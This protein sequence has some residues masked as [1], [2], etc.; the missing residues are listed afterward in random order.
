MKFLNEKRFF[1]I[2]N[3][4]SIL[5]SLIFIVTTILFFWNR[6]YK[7]SLTLDTDIFNHY[8]SFFAGIF[9]IPTTILVYLTY[10]TQKKELE[11]ARKTTQIQ[12]FENT[13]FNLLTNHREVTK[14]L[15]E[16]WYKYSNSR[17]EEQSRAFDGKI[18]IDI[19]V[20]LIKTILHGLEIKYY[21]DFVDKQWLN[22]EYLNFDGYLPFDNFRLFELNF[23]FI[24]ENKKNDPLGKVIFEKSKLANPEGLPFIYERIFV[25]NRSSL[26]HYF[27][28]LYHFVKLVDEYKG[29]DNLY[30]KDEI[31]EM[32]R[33]YVRLIRAQL[34][35]NELILLALNSISEYGKA[36]IPLIERY[37]LL[38]NVNIHAELNFMEGLLE[39][40]PHF[41]QPL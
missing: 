33:K 25:L 32:K 41:K 20:N 6:T 21:L 17:R 12:Q 3:W 37:K 24:N 14:S 19:T 5:A 30:T 2:P 29:F 35:N 10:Q 15:N 34:S 22:I 9:S 39:K 7:T 40:Y 4:L 26:G 18:L 8:G 23:E 27:R 38:K 11:D 31:C 1:G 13:F 36:F 28:N 16:S